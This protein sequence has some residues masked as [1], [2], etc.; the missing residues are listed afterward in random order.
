VQPFLHEDQ[1]SNEMDLP[2]MTIQLRIRR[3]CSLAFIPLTLAAVFG[4][5]Q[6]VLAQNQAQ[7]SQIP[8]LTQRNGKADAQTTNDIKS[9][10][11]FDERSDEE[12]LDLGVLTAS[13]PANAVCV[14]QVL[15]NSPA[16]EAGLEAGDYL[17]SVDGKQITSPSGLNK[18]I[19]IMGRD[20]EVAIKV[21]REGKEMECKVHLASKSEELPKC[22]D[23]WL[24]VILS[25][26]KNGGAKI[27]HIVTGS[28][29]SK[30]PLQ[31]GDVLVKVGS[32]EI[33]NA[34][35]FLEKIEGMGP[36]DP[37]Y[38]SFR[39]EGQVSEVEVKLG[40]FC[41]A[42]M[43]FVR[44]LNSQHLN[45]RHDE[46]QG[47]NASIELMDRAI[48]DLRNRIRELRDEVRAM[49]DVQPA[50]GAKPA[51]ANQGDV[52]IL[53]NDGK[54]K[55]VS[56]IDFQVGQGNNRQ[57]NYNR[58]YN[59]YRNNYGNGQYGQSFSPNLG[60]GYQ[61]PYGGSNNYYYRNNS[62]PY[63][64]GGYNNNWYGNRPRSGIQVGP[65]MGVY[66]Y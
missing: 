26:E 9:T 42:P 61:S 51:S 10:Q 22:H 32:V 17:L 6:D 7:Q 16:D 43:A 5:W 24:G 39:R 25:D 48:D 36:A 1:P 33:Q 44:H 29:A 34:K 54:F 23:A 53:P 58:G 38:L 56:Q 60:Y 21:W 28:P 52:S 12:T 2:K 27:E 35:S 59:P 64:Y 50:E 14:K 62:Q 19:A 18:L 8:S 37:L 63:Y 45:S 11:T 4:T 55:F 47:T 30:S 40:S 41:D 66:W 65:N 20:N 3:Q 46:Q 31:E 15:Q 13:C 57:Q 49:K